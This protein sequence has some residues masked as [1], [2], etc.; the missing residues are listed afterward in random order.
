MK[1]EYRI[2][3]NNE[4]S[5]VFNKGKSYANRQFVLYVLHKEDQ[6]HF[7]IGLSV[8]KKVG[9]AVTRNR[10]KRVIRE[11]FKELEE[12]IKENIDYVVIARNPVASMDFQEMKKSL[13][14]VMKKANVIKRSE[15][16]G[17]KRDV[18]KK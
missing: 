5:V 14:H 13:Y 18:Q 10:I 7:R 4:F 17:Q 8:S 12:E 6:K 16:A 3:K 11:I 9:H 2:K 15:R 1:K